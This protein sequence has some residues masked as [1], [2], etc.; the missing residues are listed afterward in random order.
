MRCFLLAVIALCVVA[1]PASADPIT[2]FISTTFAVSAATASSIVSLGASLLLSAAARALMPE[3][4]VDQLRGRQVSSREPVAPREIVYGDVRKGGTIVFM[5][6]TPGSRLDHELL[7][8]VIVVASHEVEEIG[9]VYLN[10]V[11]AVPPGQ[12]GA[13]GR[14]AN[15]VVVE[16]RHGNPYE[17][18]PPLLVSYTK[19]L[20]SNEHRLD[21]CAYIYV[22]MSFDMD[23]FPS[24]VPNVTVDIKGKKDIYDPRTGTRGYSNNAALCLAD[25][26]SL[27]PFGVGA[28]IGAED[29]TNEATLIANANVCD[30]VLTE[31][32]GILDFRYRCNGV[33]KLDQ[34]PKTIIE[35]MLTSMA[36]QVAWQAGQWHIYAGAYRTPTLTFTADDFAG[37][38]TLQ[39][40][41]SRQENFNGVRGQFV[42]PTNDW[43]PDDFPAYQSAVYVAEDGGEEA[44]DDI[45]LPFTTSPY[46]AQRLAKIHLERK[47]R[48]QRVTVPG[49]LNMWQATVGSVINLTYDRY[50]FASKPFEVQGVTLSLQEGALVPELVLQET[51]PLVYDHTASEFQIYEAAPST[52]LPSAF[53]IPAPSWLEVSEALYATRGSG[54]VKVKAILDWTAA[55]SA[56]V[57]EYQIEVRPN[58]T[59]T[60]QVIGRTDDTTYEVLDWQVGVWDWR[61]K[62]ISNI[63]VSSGYISVNKREIF[64]LNVLPSGI[65][66]LLIQK[67]SGNAILKWDVHPDIDVAIGGKILV[68]HSIANTPTWKSSRSYGETSGG[69]TSISFPLLAGSYL[70]RAQDSS[71]NL[72]PV[73]VV[74]T[75]DAEAVAFANI[76]TLTE[77]TAFSGVKTDCGILGNTLVLNG[78][79]SVSSWALVS[80]VPRVSSAGGYTPRGVY[81]FASGMDFGTSKSVR[82]KANVDVAI[83]STSDLISQRKGFVS[84]WQQ[85]S[86]GSGGEVD[87][88]VEARTTPDDPAGSPAWSEWSRVDRADVTARGVEARAILTSIDATYTPVVSEL[89]LSADEVV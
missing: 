36:G 6:S 47:R 21:G 3:P 65:T 68:R 20:W 25:Y 44:W 34:T 35:A 64:G 40:R 14:Y 67:A 75:D 62:A 9:A 56:F 2:A 22:L 81:E 69:Q 57:A 54:G 41:A 53:D 13:V 18:P 45:S 77:D 59:T 51:S 63:G 26:M 66:G 70:V 27:S 11:Y 60:W 37:D 15:L 58:G 23:V 48:Q 32:S 1:S 50:G 78:T 4:S 12:P 10:G 71:G 73:S 72:G 19:G 87:V 74:T 38:I 55:Q 76:T 17:T 5:H 84:T 7:H 39:T 83:G 79:G 82:L 30:E 8:M 24:G 43:Q 86:S 16:R 85:I 28:E 80:D 89:G 52:N 49:K 88:V 31:T 46:A 33:V 42:S 61:V 29:G